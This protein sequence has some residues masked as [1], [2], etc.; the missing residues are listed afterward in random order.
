M[1]RSRYSSVGSCRLLR[2]RTSLPGGNSDSFFW[3]AAVVVCACSYKTPQS[4]RIGGQRG[5][6]EPRPKV[7]IVRPRYLDICRWLYCAEYFNFGRQCLSPRSNTVYHCLRSPE[8]IPSSTDMRIC[9]LQGRRS[10]PTWPL[11]LKGFDIF[12]A[13][14]SFCACPIREM[15]TPRLT[16]HSTERRIY[17][18]ISLPSAPHNTWARY[19]SQVLTLTNFWLQSDSA[20]LKHCLWKIWVGIDMYHD[21]T[22]YLPNHNK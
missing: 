5:E 2:T 11:P 13:L 15:K 9:F 12:K 10:H 22:R 3:E 19:H 1:L 6:F 21:E 8:F 18:C 4:M 16:I 20:T 14:N 7:W 17:T